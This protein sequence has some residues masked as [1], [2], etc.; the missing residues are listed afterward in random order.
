MLHLL[1]ANGFDE[2]LVTVSSALGYSAADADSLLSLHNRLNTKVAQ[3]DP[4]KLADHIPQ[5]KKYIPNLEAYDR[6]LVKAGG[7]KC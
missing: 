3:L 1:K 7:E 5:L 4:I 6:S 2:A